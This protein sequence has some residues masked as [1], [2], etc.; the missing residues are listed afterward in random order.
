MFGVLMITLLLTIALV[1]SNMDVILKQGIVIK[2]EQKLR[3]IQL[4]LKAFQLLKN[5]IT[6]F[7]IKL[8]N[9]LRHLDL[10]SHGI[11]HKELGLLCIKY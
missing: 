7:K 8:T 11:R 10:M 2:L 6:L 3:K 9:G 1:G 5:L 4:L